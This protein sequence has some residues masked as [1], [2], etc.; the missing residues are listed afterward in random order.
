MPTR[1]EYFLGA[2]GTVGQDGPLVTSD[3]VAVV[4]E[5][6]ASATVV[7]PAIGGVI[8]DAAASTSGARTGLTELAWQGSPWRVVW[9]VRSDGLLW[10]MTYRADQ[11][12]YGWSRHPFA[13]G[14]VQ[15]VAVI[16][17]PDTGTDDLYLA[18]TRQVGGADV[19]HVEVL[20]DMFR[21][22]SADDGPDAWHLDCALAY[23]GVATT[24]LSGLDHLEGL[25]V[26]VWTDGTA[27]ADRVVQAGAITLDWATTKAVVG[28]NFASALVTLPYPG[29]PGAK[30]LPKQLLIQLRST[31]GLRLGRDEDNLVSVA[32]R[33]ASASM[34]TATPLFSGWK[35]VALNTTHDRLGTVTAASDGAAP[36]TILSARIM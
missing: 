17:N 28:I 21:P 22:T 10:G 14:A 2:V 31:A 18:V 11:N 8:T 3:P 23:D 33:E 7:T 13:G 6:D 12:V 29:D 36:L 25:T 5:T 9:V 24:T 34:D 32:F 26:G 30:K 4:T 16:P 27:H 35:D 1:E 19:T 20:T 15:S